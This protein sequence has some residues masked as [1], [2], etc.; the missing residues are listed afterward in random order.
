[1][2][3]ALTL[4]RIIEDPKQYKKLLEPL[5]AENDRRDEQIK[6]LGNAKEINALH[7]K[8]Q[9]FT[10]EASQRLQRANVESQELVATA[11]AKAL[12]LITQAEERVKQLTS[13][14]ERKLES[15]KTL[16]AEADL[17]LKQS[18]KD[19]IQLNV[20][21]EA[22]KKREQ[23][24]KKREDVLERREAAIKKANEQLSM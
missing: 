4:F 2:K 10:A 18:K 21:A 7:E 20:A 1:M 5:I 3:D 15:A 14:T 19:Q 11:E 6:T 12:E 24:A 23:N 17:N 22:I 9:K 8:A 16:Q 13:V